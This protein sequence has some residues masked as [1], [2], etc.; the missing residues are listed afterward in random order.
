MRDRRSTATCRCDAELD[1]RVKKHRSE[2]IG[3]PIRGQK[4]RSEVA[5]HQYEV[6][7]RAIGGHR[8]HSRRCRNINPRAAGERSD[9]SGELSRSPESRSEVARSSI[10]GIAK[11][12]CQAGKSPLNVTTWRLLTRDQNA[13]ETEDHV[14]LIPG[15][16]VT[17]PKAK[18]LRLAR[19][20]AAAAQH[21]PI[22]LL[23]PPVVAVGH[24]LPDIP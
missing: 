15:N 22:L 23:R 18:L 20:P 8:T 9:P 11:V 19:C 6:S 17:I 4:Q 3:I 13:A 16:D 12:V 5:G 10:Q 21:P 1:R 7:R 2:V 24:P 14:P